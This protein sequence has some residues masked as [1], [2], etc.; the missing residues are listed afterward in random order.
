M[1]VFRMPVALVDVLDHQKSH[2][3]ELISSF[4]RP[5]YNV[6]FISGKTSQHVPEP[7]YAVLKISESKNA[8]SYPLKKTQS[9]WFYWHLMGHLLVAETGPMTNCCKYFHLSFMDEDTKRG[10]T[11][12][13]PMN[14]Q[15]HSTSQNWRQGHYPGLPDLSSGFSPLLAV[16]VF[17]DVFVY[18]SAG[19]G[20]G[21]AGIFFFITSSKPYFLF[22]I[23]L[24]HPGHLI[25]FL[26]AVSA[27]FG[28]KK[29]FSK[30]ITSPRTLC[31]EKN[32]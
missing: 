7:V 10:E 15:S 11:Q 32:A 23:S 21:A 17:I 1:F 25:A 27:I 8:N 16:L 4:G 31:W 19:E 13:D 28:G 9:D 2:A 26:W 14:Y 5:T 29:R 12:R 18:F 22:V 20:I 3:L 30:K 24:F 6:Y